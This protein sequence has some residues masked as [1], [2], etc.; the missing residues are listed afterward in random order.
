MPFIIINDE[1]LSMSLIKN[2]NTVPTKEL[3]EKYKS[4]VN[5]EIHISEFIKSQKQNGVICREDFFS[6]LLSE[7]IK[8]KDKS[9][10][11]DILEENIYKNNYPYLLTNVDKLQLGPLAYALL[12][13]ENGTIQN[14]IKEYLNK[15]Q[16]FQK[17]RLTKDA[18]L[19]LHDIIS[20]QGESYR[21]CIDVFLKPVIN[22]SAIKLLGENTIS[23]ADLSSL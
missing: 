22:D 23:D 19:K 21:E 8:Q 2:Y 16:Y 13:D 15:G 5:K 4:S 1:K 20:Y 12:L 6:L 10:V 3:Y 17:M 7:A 18:F 14:I 11:K 9:L